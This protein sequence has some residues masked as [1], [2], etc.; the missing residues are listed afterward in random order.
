MARKIMP[1]QRASTIRI[2]EAKQNVYSAIIGEKVCMKIGD[3]SWSPSRRE[4]TLNQ[5]P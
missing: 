1:C 5:W 3:G 4:W 2:L